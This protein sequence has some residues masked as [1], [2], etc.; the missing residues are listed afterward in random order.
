VAQGNGAVL[1]LRHTPGT[2]N[3]IWG[4]E[5]PSADHLPIYQ[6]SRR[7]TSI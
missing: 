2:G 5:Q 3:L 7:P 6:V 1:R 4:K